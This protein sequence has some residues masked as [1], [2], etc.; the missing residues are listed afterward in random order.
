LEPHINKKLARKKEK[1]KYKKLKKCWN[2]IIKYISK[3]NIPERPGNYRTLVK[4][5]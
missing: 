2:R 3:K 5:D 4:E 1:R